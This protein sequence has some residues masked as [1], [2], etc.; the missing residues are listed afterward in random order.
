MLSQRSKRS[1]APIEREHLDRLAALADIQHAQFVR[2]GVRA[3]SW[4]NRRIAVVLA[5]GGARHYL[6]GTTGVKDFDVWTFYAAI[7]GMPLRC[8]R[9]ETHADF[10]P[11]VH[12][13]Q[14]YPTDF[15]HPQKATWLSYEGR[16]VDFMVRDLHV[17]V[18]ATTNKITHAL[19]AWLAAGANNRSARTPSS[20]HLSR[21]AMIWLEPAEPGALIWP[22]P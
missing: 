2:E 12:G 21:Q 11:S 20:W 19:R 18:G 5:Q 15:E 3:Y 8:G 22:N 16:R 1:L 13:R 14:Q 9:Y 7:P 10:S 17:A 4:A 6:D